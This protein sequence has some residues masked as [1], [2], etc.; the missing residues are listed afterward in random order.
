MLLPQTFGHISI[1]GAERHRGL[2]TAP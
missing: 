2:R 1:N